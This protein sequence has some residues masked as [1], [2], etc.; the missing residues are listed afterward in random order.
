MFS[1]AS[2]V[3]YVQESRG[4]SRRRRRHQA[5]HRTW[6]FLQ[7][8]LIHNER[9]TK[10]KQCVSCELSMNNVRES[11]EQSFLVQAKAKTWVC[12]QCEC[13]VWR[14]PFFVCTKCINLHKSSS[15]QLILWSCC[16]TVKLAVTRRREVNTDRWNDAVR[17][18][19]WA[20]N[21][22]LLL[23]HASTSLDRKQTSKASN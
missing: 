16:S 2:L 9:S 6:K 11:L 4:N 22:G 23:G 20:K 10:N 3:T 17:V 15:I 7:K 18:L 13:R 14:Y 5:W 1:Q 21:V 19:A 12:E 8:E